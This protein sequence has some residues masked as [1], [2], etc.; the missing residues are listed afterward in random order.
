V[1][2]QRGWGSETDCALCPPGAKAQI[3]L[4]AYAALK[5]RSSTLLQALTKRLWH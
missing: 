3:N 1:G 5:R 2:A 4:R